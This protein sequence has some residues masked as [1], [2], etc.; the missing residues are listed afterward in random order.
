MCAGSSLA[1]NPLHLKM[2][3]GLTRWAQP[4]PCKRKQRPQPKRRKPSAKDCRRSAFPAPLQISAKLALGMGTLLRCC[5]GKKRAALRSLRG[6]KASLLQKGPSASRAPRTRC[7]KSLCRS[8]SMGSARMPRI[9]SAA[10][11]ALPMWKRSTTN[12]LAN[13]PLPGRLPSA[14]AI[15]PRCVAMVRTM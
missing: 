7:A 6:T 11:M 10:S 2:R 15:A 12:L 13:F 4:S 14:R 3:F 1:S 5:F 8:F 9:S